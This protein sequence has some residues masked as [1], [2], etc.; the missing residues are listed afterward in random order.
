MVLV[1][2]GPAIAES[3]APDRVDL[4]GDW[5]RASF[6]VE[7]SDTPETRARGLMY[8]KKMDRFAG[9]L[10]V[11]DAPM[12]ARFWMK[13]TLIPLD[14]L[15]LGPDGRVR[16]IVENAEPQSLEPRDGGPGV[17]YVLEINGGTAAR[18][19]IAPGNALRHPRIDSETA[20][21][22]CP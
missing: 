6:T 2:G 17:A 4:R 22:P 7:V 19:G 3:C 16:R 1:L 5:G 11:F 12:H 18:L 8:R 10:F 21:W 15:F 13:N 20:A 9:M 14:M